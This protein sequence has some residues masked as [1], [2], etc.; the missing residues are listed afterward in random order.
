M[1]S[2]FSCFFCGEGFGK[3]RSIRRDWSFP[4][5]PP[6][7]PDLSDVEEDNEYMYPQKIALGGSAPLAAPAANVVYK[8]DDDDIGYSSDGGSDKNN[9]VNGSDNGGNSTPPTGG[10]GDGGYE[11]ADGG[12]G[13]DGGYASGD[14]GEEGGGDGNYGGEDDSSYGGGGYESA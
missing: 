9:P 6:L 8:N 13:S 11:Y 3:D 12:Y 10:Y 1:A 4:H 14:G 5:S 2:L 7:D